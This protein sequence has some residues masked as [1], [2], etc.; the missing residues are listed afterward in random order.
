MPTSQHR[1]AVPDGRIEPLRLLACPGS[2]GRE[3]VAVLE[4]PG[5]ELFLDRFDECPDA[6]GIFVILCLLDEFLRP[7]EFPVEGIEF[8]PLPCFGPVL[9]QLESRQEE[10]FQRIGLSVDPGWNRGTRPTV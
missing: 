2:P 6:L 3:I 4:F 7:F 5:R 8:L 10:Q 9:R 1:V